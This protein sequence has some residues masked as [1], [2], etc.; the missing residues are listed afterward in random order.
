VDDALMMS[1]GLDIDGVEAAWR[2]SVMEE[3]ARA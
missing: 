3:L 2:A 1:F